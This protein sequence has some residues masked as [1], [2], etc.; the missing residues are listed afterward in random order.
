MLA[1]GVVSY[2]MYLWHLDLMR[3]FVEPALG[4]DAFGEGAFFTVLIGG[5]IA[6]ATVAALSYFA[7]ERPLTRLAR[8]PRPRQ[9]ARS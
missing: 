8:G 4:S 6:S 5:V 9:A 3:R 7:V 2:G 1:L